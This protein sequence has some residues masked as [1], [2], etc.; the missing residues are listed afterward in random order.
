MVD[1]VTGL[2]FSPDRKMVALIHKQQPLR[3]CGRV[4]GLGG[5]VENGESPQQA[6]SREVH[7]EAGILVPPES[8]TTFACIDRTPGDFVT[9]LFAYSGKIFRAKTMES[10]RVELFPVG[11]LP[12]NVIWNLR[13]LIPLAQDPA[14]EFAEPVRIVDDPRPDVVA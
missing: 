1:Y 14:L 12:E 6:I 10:E 8:W 4:N 7:E 11:Q 13:W 9:C 3:Q 5:K 2:L